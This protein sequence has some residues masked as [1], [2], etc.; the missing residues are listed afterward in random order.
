MLMPESASAP[1]KLAL[2]PGCDRIPAPI[3]EI[4][5]IRSSKIS[6]S[7]PTSS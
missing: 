6:E 7:N 4:L 3:S 2:T 5:P 1:K